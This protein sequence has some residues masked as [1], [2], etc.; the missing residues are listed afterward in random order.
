MELEV[1]QEMYDRLATA[2][3]AQVRHPRNFR[4]PCGRLISERTFD[5]FGFGDGFR[6]GFRDYDY[7]DDELP[8]DQEIFVDRANSFGGGITEEIISERSNCFGGGVG[9]VKEEIIVDRPSRFGGGGVG[10]NEEIIVDR[11]SRF[12]GVG[13][14][15]GIL[16]EEIFGNLNNYEIIRQNNGQ[17]IVVY[18][19]NE[20]EKLIEEFAPV[21]GRHLP[22]DAKTQIVK[23]RPETIVHRQSPIIIRRPPTRVVINHPP[24]VV[25][26]SAV[27]FHREGTRVEQP[28]KHIHLPRKVKV[29]PYVVEKEIPIEKKII[30]ENKIEKSCGCSK[31]CGCAER[32]RLL[33]GSV[34]FDNEL[35]ATTGDRFL[36]REA[37]A[38][39]EIAQNNVDGTLV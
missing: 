15:G 33:E 18:A 20:G 3:D 28:V 37:V 12:G 35:T 25:K 39:K 14:A 13:G 10:V 32:E 38:D 2:Y 8:I 21:E 31:P 36:K 7:I 30:V 9:G 26:P 19:A 4:L 22:C 23:G 11:A 24:M 34:F 5:N 1:N 27:I 17:P 29:H 6:D 16:N